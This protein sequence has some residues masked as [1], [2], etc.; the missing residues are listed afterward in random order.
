MVLHDSQTIHEFAN[1]RLKL[2]PSGKKNIYRG[3]V[4]L[5]HQGFLLFRY[6]LEIDFS[7]W[8]HLFPQVR[9]CDGLIPWTSENHVY[10]DGS[11]CLSTV[12]KQQV[13]IRSGE[14]ATLE[15]FLHKVLEPHLVRQAEY[16]AGNRKV[17][18]KLEY[19]HGELGILETYL[20]ILDATSWEVI[21]RTIRCYLSHLVVPI[22]HR[23]D[24]CCSY[25]TRAVGFGK[26]RAKILS[27]I[28]TPRLK[29]DLHLLT[30]TYFLIATLPQ[31][32]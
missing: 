22:N 31:R 14:I 4:S 32:E 13:L 19:S 11:L 7:P 8:P 28:D 1:E 2:T 25:Y 12:P 16:S 6:Y 27:Y 17:F 26:S 23:K 21:S 24:C 10:D 29:A 18:K 30:K 9:E 15:L 5:K 3:R 20:N